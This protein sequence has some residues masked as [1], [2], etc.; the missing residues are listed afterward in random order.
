MLGNGS[1]HYDIALVDTGAAVSLLTAQAHS[2][3]NMDGP[4]P[5]EPEGFGGTEEIQIGGATGILFAE[6]NDPVGL[7]AGGLQGRTGTG[8]FVMNHSALEGQTNTSM[9][10]VPA[11]SDLPNMLGLTFASQYATRF[12]AICLKFSR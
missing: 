2:D 1:A 10:T 12:A 11:E 8:P 7:Y 4:Y 3:F 9:V 6:I 5:G